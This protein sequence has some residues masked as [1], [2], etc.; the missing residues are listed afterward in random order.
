MLKSS[1]Y[2]IGI[3]G[4][5]WLGLWACGGPL[6]NVKKTFN[7][8]EYNKTI[9]QLNELKNGG[10]NTEEVNRLLGES[11]RRSNRIQEAEKFYR[12]ALDLNSNND[13]VRYYYAQALKANGKY[14]EASKQF[15]TYSKTGRNSEF[16]RQARNEVQNFKKV[17]ELLNKKTYYE[18]KNCEGINTNAAEFA[19]SIY[20]DKI[21]FSST[22][23]SGIYEGTGASFAG[24]FA[25]KIQDWDNCSGVT[26]PFNEKIMLE[27]VNETSP[28][29]APDGSFMIFARSGSG[30]KN[31][32]AEVDLY[33]S[34]KT[35]DGWSEPE[36]LPYPININ[37]NLAEAGND[38]LKG[39]KE[40][41]WTA[42]PFIRPDGKRLYFASNRKGGGY[43]GV[44]IWQADINGSRIVN[45][46]NL[47][48]DINT[49]GNE[50]FPVVSDE[51]ELYFASDGHPGFGGL[52]MFKAVRK[53]G[54]TTIQ[55]LGAPMNSRS[56]DFGMIFK[57]DTT[58]YFT[59]NREGGKGDDDI[60]SFRD[61]TPDK[62]ILRYFLKIQVVGIDPTDKTKKEVPLGSA[63]IDFFAGN[64]FN[65]EKKLNDFTTKEDGKT[66]KFGVEVPANFAIAVDAGDDYFRDEFDYSTFGRSIAQDAVKDDPRVEIDTTFETKVIME[67]IVVDVDTVVRQIDINFDY[68]KA[69][70]RPDAMRILDEFVD[71]LQKNPQI[72]V[73]MG[74]HTDAV[75]TEQNNLMLSQRR[76]DSTV[77]YLVQ[78]GIAPNRLNPRG[79]GESKLKVNTQ[80]ANEENRRT[81]M[82]VIRIDRNRRKRN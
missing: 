44:D 57:T 46:R 78:K 19:P 66:D 74:S 27:G 13:T 25:H 81:E 5:L 76:A 11:Y 29:F 47:G 38:N 16:I 4:G 80:E 35:D 68:N 34:R 49:A 40:N 45:I 79:Y 1:L 54:A 53:Q 24:I 62:K 26:E 72:D 58:G 37:R 71:F 36:I 42:C 22:R 32:S 7:K 23:K 33:I 43:G 28:T 10:M 2:K 3:V 63:K 41:V 75:G 65:K 73:E 8:A 14:Q 64:K 52:D 69:D 60:Y 21:L 31:E 55:N 51:G 70:I 30:K 67:K 9:A 59:S 39:S 82:K 50:L 15:E 77:A 12:A 6:K 18:V 56:D 61:I 17:E 20:Y 48:R